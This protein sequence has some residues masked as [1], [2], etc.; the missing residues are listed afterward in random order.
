MYKKHF[1][2]TALP[3]LRDAPRPILR[4]ALPIRHLHLGYRRRERI[5]SAFIPAVLRASRLRRGWRRQPLILETQSAPRRIHLPPRTLHAR[6]GGVLLHGRGRGRRGVGVVRR[7][8]GRHPQ[9]H[10]SNGVVLRERWRCDRDQSRGSVRVGASGVFQTSE[11]A[12][13]MRGGRAI[14]V[15]ADRRHFSENGG[16]NGRGRG[17][18]GRE[19]WGTGR[20]SLTRE[21]V[22]GVS[23]RARP[24]APRRRLRASEG[25]ALEAPRPRRK[26]ASRL[27][28]RAMLRV[29]PRGSE[30]DEPNAALD[31]ALLVVSFVAERSGATRVLGGAQ[32]RVRSLR[33]DG[34]RNQTGVG[35]R[36]KEGTRR[37]VALLSAKSSRARD[38]L[39]LESRTLRN[40]QTAAHTEFERRESITSPRTLAP[41][42][43][44]SM[45]GSHSG[46]GEVL[47]AF[48]PYGFQ[49]RTSGA[50]A[51][52]ALVGINSRHDAR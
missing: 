46:V 32:R 42:D 14:A 18:N 16:G 30:T 38:G 49:S 50:F 36:R 35:R 33:G 12:A 20:S 22:R 28:A 11:I 34:H 39:I 45:T 2:S 23:R 4:R 24:R 7:R 25:G 5:A 17:G 21:V 31:G 47:R 43:R 15:H 9:E 40:F 29:S 1:T 8:C 26:F 10:H 41:D 6:R 48:F 44:L 13:R 19:G 52:A 3:R 51:A 27:G 37:D